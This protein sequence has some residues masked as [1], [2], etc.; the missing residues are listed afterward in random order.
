MDLTAGQSYNSCNGV[1]N[2]ANSIGWNIPAGLV[3][4][5]RTVHTSVHTSAAEIVD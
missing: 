1:V 3:G 4:R 5:A 2:N